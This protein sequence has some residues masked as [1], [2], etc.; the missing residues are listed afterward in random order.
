[1][2]DSYSHVTHRSFG[3]NLIE[4]IKGILVGVVLFFVSFPLLWWN[5][6]RL[7]LSTVAKRAVVVKPDAGGSDGDGKLIAVTAPLKVDGQIGDPDFLKPGAHVSL[8]RDVEMYA[9]V[10]T[11]KTETKKKLGG[12]SDEITTYT[13]DKKWTSSPRDS[14]EFAHPEG[15]RN[16]TLGVS[17]RTF[18]ADK[19]SVGG[20]SFSPEEL[21]LPSRT[22]V[23]LHKD[24]VIGHGRVL[25]QYLYQGDGTMDSPKLGDVRISFGA[26]EPGKTSTL[27]GK[28]DGQTVVAYMHEGKD[29]LYRVLSGTHEEAIATMHGEHTT[30]T[31]ILRLVGFLM[32]WF[33]LALV[34]GPI[35]AVL[36]V[37]PFLGSTG[38]ALTSIL[39]FPIAL[40]LSGVTILI[41]IVAHNPILL[42]AVVVAFAGGVGFLIKRRRDQK[43][44]RAAA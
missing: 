36:D 14:D 42:V 43:A 8:R 17:A 3:D 34:L 31:W 32:M 11:K 12:G 24:R 16:P 41:S 18:Y 22:P 1:M 13:Y 21:E 15:H 9:W 35:N 40:A 5:E 19:A 38:R 39:L 2:S 23:E 37:I 30:M 4:S 10:E 44:A 7:D 20:L 29:K 25:G 33:G 27:Y 26:V 6:G 28:R